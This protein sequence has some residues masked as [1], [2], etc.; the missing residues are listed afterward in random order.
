[1][2]IKETNQRFRVRKLLYAKLGYP[3]VKY[4]RWIVQ[5]RQI[6]DCPVT[7]QD[8]GGPYQAG[9]PNHSTTHQSIIGSL[10]I[11]THKNSTSAG[12]HSTTQSTGHETRMT[13]VNPRSAQVIK[14]K[15]SDKTILYT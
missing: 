11:S 8:M 1:M 12:N 13:K 5:S 15:V 4:F 10:I 14:N 3:S 2:I 7:V 9:V 6:I